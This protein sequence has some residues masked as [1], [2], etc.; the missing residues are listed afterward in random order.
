MAPGGRHP[1][2]AIHLS[3]RDG[4]PLIK[5]GL[6]VH[7]ENFSP[8]TPPRSAPATRGRSCGTPRRAGTTPRTAAAATERCPCESHRSHA[9]AFGW[10]TIITLP[11]RVRSCASI[12]LSLVGH[13]ENAAVRTILRAQPAADAVILD[14]DLLVPCRGGSNPPGNRPCNGRPCTSGR[15]S[16]RRNC[17]SASRRAAAAKRPV[18]CEC[19]PVLLDAAPRALV[20][21]RASVQVEH[22]HALRL[23]K[24]LLDVFVEHFHRD[25]LARAAARATS[26]TIRRPITGNSRIICR[27][28]SR[29]S[30]ASSRC[31]SAEQVAVR[32]PGRIAWPTRRRSRL[33]ASARERRRK[34]RPRSCGRPAAVNP[35]SPISPMIAPGTA[36]QH[37][38]L[39]RRKFAAR[40]GRGPIRTK[41]SALATSPCS[42]NA[43]PG[44][45][46][47]NVMR[48]RR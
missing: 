34:P 30:R 10:P 26:P 43:W 39:R 12:S 24:P 13:H 44:V 45:T 27:K 1:P 47:T 37:L 22:E 4:D 29:P 40:C 28:S 19:V 2:F 23:V 15:R 35:S 7:P 17:R 9:A 14:D 8:L 32:V 48:G 3:S 20:A 11:G 5:T 33:P 6:L 18:P 31:P 42:N 21:T 16:P 38:R 41:Y 46:R 25:A 36:R